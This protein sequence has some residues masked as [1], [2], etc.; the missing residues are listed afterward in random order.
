MKNMITHQK[1]VYSWQFVFLAS[2][3]DAQ[4]VGTSYGISGQG[5]QGWQGGVGLRAAYAATSNAVGNYRASKN[6][7]AVVNV[8]AT[9]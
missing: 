8:N 7:N 2:N 3:M 1:D 9:P 4:V 6:P 5:C